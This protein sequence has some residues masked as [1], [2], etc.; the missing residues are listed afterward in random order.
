MEYLKEPGLTILDSDN[1]YYRL[2]IS[3]VIN[4]T[5]NLKKVMFKLLRPIFHKSA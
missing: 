5:C 3:A 1:I 2:Y 4:Q